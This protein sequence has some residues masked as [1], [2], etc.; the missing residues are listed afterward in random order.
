MLKAAFWAYP[1]EAPAPQSLKDIGVPDGEEGAADVGLMIELF[2]PPLFRKVSKSVVVD[3]TIGFPPAT[4]VLKFAMRVGTNEASTMCDSESSP[5]DASGLT[6]KRP[7]P[8][9]AWL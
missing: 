8:F 2:E 9:T 3:E 6:L 7:E 4:G 1:A 5:F